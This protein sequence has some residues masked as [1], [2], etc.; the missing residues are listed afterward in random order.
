L[1]ERSVVPI[2]GKAHGK[3]FAVRYLSSREMEAAISVLRKNSVS[4]V[5]DAEISRLGTIREARTETGV[6]F[7]DC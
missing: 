1:G 3:I 2:T 4:L 5:Q 6:S 7:S